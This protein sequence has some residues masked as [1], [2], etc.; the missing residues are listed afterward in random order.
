MTIYEGALQCTGGTGDG[1]TVTLSFVTQGSIP[2]VN[3]SQITVQNAVPSGWN[4]NWTV[5]ASSTSSVSFLNSTSGSLTNPTLAYINA[6]FTLT[7]LSGNLATFPTQGAPPFNVGDN[8]TFKGC[9][10]TNY[11]GNFIVT[12]CT[13]STVTVLSAV[14]GTVTQL[15]TVSPFVASWS[16]FTG[17]Q[18]L[19]VFEITGGLYPINNGT[20]LIIDNYGNLN[21]FGN[22]VLNSGN[23]E[24]DTLNNGGMA[25][26]GSQDDQ[27]PGPKIFGHSGGSLNTNRTSGTFL[28]CLS[29]SYTQNFDATVT[30]GSVTLSTC[31]VNNNLF[32]AGAAN[33]TEG[34]LL[35]MLLP[36]LL[37][38][39]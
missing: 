12:A 31:L 33:I 26:Y 18:S 25:Y 14:T 22:I 35:V 39:L 4:G 6:S 32:V 3:G 21:V 30:T 1:T 9:I 5:S 11:N 7:A 34:R 20:P 36:E 15:G 17:T 29:W 37:L 28:R 23:F 19:P 24:F 8:V 2:F 13:A 38:L 27:G 16:I 10:P